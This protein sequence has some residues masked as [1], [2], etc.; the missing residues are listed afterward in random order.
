MAWDRVEKAAI[1]A[2]TVLVALMAVI[3]LWS[4]VAYDTHEFGDTHFILGAAWRQYLG[5][6]PTVD[7]EHFYGGFTSWVIAQA[8]ALFGPSVHAYDYALLMML[9]GFGL[10]VAAMSW[11]R[12]SGLGAA[13]ALLVIATLILTRQPLELVQSVTRIYSSHASLYNRVGLVIVVIVGLFAAL[14]SRSRAAELMGGAVTGG[15][16]VTVMLT[17]PTFIVLMPGVFLA[18]LV[19]SRWTALAATTVAILA[20]LMI[21]DPWGARWLASFEYARTSAADRAD[22]NVAPLIRKALQLPLAQPLALTLV[23][24]TII[25]LFISP[26]RPWGQV[27]SLAL[28]AGSGLGMAAT[29]GGGGSLGQLS[30]PILAMATLAGAELAR[31]QSHSQGHAAMLGALVLGAGFSLPHAANLAGSTLEAW[32]KR[33]QIL[34]VGGP[35][36]DYLSVVEGNLPRTDAQYPMLAEGIETLRQFGDL[37]DVGIV[38]TNGITFEFALQARPVPGYPLWPRAIAPELAPG[39]PMPP[40]TD[41]VLL[42][43]GEQADTRIGGVLRQK[44]ADDFSPCVETEYWSIFVRTEMTRRWC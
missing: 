6:V 39:A 4:P 30:L 1:I 29:M 12:I 32:N 20:I 36:S 17:K 14:P 24:A 41:I 23:I 25:G 44:M 21:I 27:L 18:L 13:I 16:L 22:A 15:L 2:I 31:R 38:A 9:A 3:V 35:L 11:K 26:P 10:T 28:V 43:R 42:G 8:I 33:D 37:S 5:L 40:D 34:I 7:F 19:Q